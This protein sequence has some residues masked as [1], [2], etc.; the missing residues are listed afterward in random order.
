MMVGGSSN[1]RGGKVKVAQAG[2]FEG[3][4]GG[5]VREEDDKIG[6]S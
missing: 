6:G 3:G 5:G 2:G 1:C 4:G